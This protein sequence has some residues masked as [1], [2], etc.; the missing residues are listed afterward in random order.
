VRV[1]LVTATPSMSEKSAKRRNTVQRDAPIAR[2]ASVAQ[3]ALIWTSA[4]HRF[5]NGLVITVITGA[6]LS[7][8]LIAKHYSWSLGGGGICDRGERPQIGASDCTKRRS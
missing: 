3:A 4:R 1:E 5:F 7:F 6:V 8:L 2:G